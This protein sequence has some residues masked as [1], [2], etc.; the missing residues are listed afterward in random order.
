MQLGFILTSGRRRGVAFVVRRS[1]FV[2]HLHH[3]TPASP[4]A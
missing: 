4:A 2:G 3:I 1:S